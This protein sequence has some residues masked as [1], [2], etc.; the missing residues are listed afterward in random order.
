[1]NL[2]QAFR[3]RNEVLGRFRLVRGGQ[4]LVSNA[5][6]AVKLAVGGLLRGVAY[7]ITFPYISRQL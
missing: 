1:M 5:Y 7:R 4:S 6:L 3:R 2:L